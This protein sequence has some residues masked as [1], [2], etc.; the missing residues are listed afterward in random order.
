MGAAADTMVVVAV[1]TVIWSTSRSRET[2]MSIASND[3]AT[4]VAIVGAGIGGLVLAHGLRQ[5][6]FEVTVLER[7]TDLRRTV[8]H[9][10]QLDA[11]AM[12]ALQEMM[13]AA[14]MRRLYALAQGVWV[15]T[16][17]AVRDQTG[18]LLAGS[19]DVETPEGV[20]TDR[21]T[22]RLML[23]D[24]LDEVLRSGAEVTGYHRR[25]SGKVSISLSGSE[26]IEADLLVAA[27]GVG[28][29]IATQ[30]AGHPTS[31]SS[32]LVGF[33][34]RTLVRELSPAALEMYGSGALIAV[35]PGGCGLYSGR[36]ESL[37]QELVSSFT[38]EPLHAE[39]TI[40]WG[41]VMLEWARTAPLSELYGEEL[42]TALS[43]ELRSREW[44]PQ[45]VE[46]V[47]RAETASVTGFPFHVSPSYPAGIAP[48]QPSTVT[49]LG[50]AVHAMPPTGGMG[51]STAIRDAHVLWKEL[52]S[53]Q[54]GEQSVVGAVAAYES[55]MRQYAAAV[56]AAARRPAAWVINGPGTGGAL[57][58]FPRERSLAAAA[59]SWAQRARPVPALV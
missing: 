48:W 26:E 38:P 13:P 4:T 42:R 9:G 14:W 11:V 28:S 1:T 49:A 27:D 53:V 10:L 29:R 39:P 32:A 56:V 35:G 45:L 37:D 51:A 34:G 54:A 3:P 2:E 25:P 57:L 33:A 47:E 8:G 21:L 23:A 19:R 55:A 43:H 16:G 6:G 31:E 50:D 36:H 22:L 40:V 17:Y 20:M 30:L 24:D 5:R 7:E 15:E 44:S 59:V 41:A 18:R 12:E 52:V 58:P 46:V